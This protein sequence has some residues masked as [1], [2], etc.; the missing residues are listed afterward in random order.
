MQTHGK[1]FDFFWFV[2]TIWML[3]F[4]QSFRSWFRSSSVAARKWFLSLYFWHINRNP[5]SSFIL[6][7]A[8]SSVGLCFYVRWP[9]RESFKAIHSIVSSL[10]HWNDNSSVFCR[11]IHAH[12]VTLDCLIIMCTNETKAQR[13]NRERERKWLEKPKSKWMKRINVIFGSAYV[14]VRGN[15]ALPW[16]FQENT[17]SKLAFSC[18]KMDTGRKWAKP[19]ASHLEI[20][21][22]RPH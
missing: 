3:S 16:V 2:S 5:N 11:H 20:P 14:C 7:N 6:L 17:H 18:D 19:F 1:S 10:G 15:S 8:L 12:S 22:L 4:N 13:P 9:T 21:H